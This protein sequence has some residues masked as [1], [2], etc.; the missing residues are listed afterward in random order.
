MPT[1]LATAVCLGAC[2]TTD[3]PPEPVPAAPPATRAAAAE[4][5]ATAAEPA[6]DVGESLIEVID[7]PAVAQTGAPAEALDPDE[8]ICR[9][10]VRT[11]TH[12]A[13]RV[14]RTRAEIERLEQE[15]KDTF[16]G[17]HESQMQ[18]NRAQ[19]VRRP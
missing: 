14:C 13:V 18:E 1:L 8:R 4:S 7:V 3:T 5:A 6:A 9:R 15:S 12:R 17:M 19:E 2:A 16:R 11:G 10:E